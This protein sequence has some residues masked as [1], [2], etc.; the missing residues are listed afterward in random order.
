MQVQFST[1]ATVRSSNLIKDHL[2]KHTF[3]D[4]DVVTWPM[5]IQ[6]TVPAGPEARS[7]LSLTT[8]RWSV[9][10]DVAERDIA[11]VKPFLG[12]ETQS[13]DQTQFFLRALP[14]HTRVVPRQSSS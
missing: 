11:L 13:E 5:A 14:L 10:K 6:P 2:G 12:Q 3:L 8:I 7:R 1:R 9:A 4:E